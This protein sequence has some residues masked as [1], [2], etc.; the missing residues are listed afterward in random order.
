MK[1]ATTVLSPREAMI[2]LARAW[3][4]L[5]NDINSHYKVGSQGKVMIDKRITED[6]N[7][8]SSIERKLK[9][10][11]LQQLLNDARIIGEYAKK[12]KNFKAAESLLKEIEVLLKSIKRDELI[13]KR[14]S[15]YLRRLAMQLG[16]NVRKIERDIE[17]EQKRAQIE[18]E[19]TFKQKEIKDKGKIFNKILRQKKPKQLKIPFK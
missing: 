5:F 2:R 12:N 17:K 11:F 3:R 19:K 13:R 9:D 8:F 18:L 6:L 7:I 10:S 16:G 15:A 14:Q 4:P 1:K